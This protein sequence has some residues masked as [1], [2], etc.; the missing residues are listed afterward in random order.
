MNYERIKELARQAYIADCKTCFP[1]WQE[2]EIVTLL[3]EDLHGVFVNFAE[4]IIA[5]LEH[6]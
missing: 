3:L 4:L 5:E 2:T 1:D 6:K